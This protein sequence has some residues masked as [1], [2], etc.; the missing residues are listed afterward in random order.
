ME[1]YVHHFVVL[2]V[3]S[4]RRLD[5]YDMN[6]IYR[7]LRDDEPFEVGVIINERVTGKGSFRI[8]DAE[9]GVHGEFIQAWAKET[10]GNSSYVDLFTKFFN[11]PEG[12]IDSDGTL[13]GLDLF[14]STGTCTLI[15]SAYE[16]KTLSCFE[17]HVISDG[18]EFLLYHN[19]QP[20]DERPYID[21]ERF[22]MSVINMG[23]ILTR[24]ER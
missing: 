11:C 9:K 21:L 2:A 10:I 15:T 12:M 19:I 5:D 23:D 6:E 13:S 20:T 8:I 18:K 7:N 24:V 22:M 3:D 4:I 17:I 1:E 16:L 14:Y